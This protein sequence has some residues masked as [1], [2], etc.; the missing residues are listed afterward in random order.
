MKTSDTFEVSKKVISP[1]SIACQ[2]LEWLEPVPI[3]ENHLS[4]QLG[5]YGYSSS[6]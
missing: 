1:R 4:Y 3:Q 2:I 5:A 6:E